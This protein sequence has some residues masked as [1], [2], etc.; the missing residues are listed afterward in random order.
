[1]DQ[2]A[3]YTATKLFLDA[4][5]LSADGI[6]LPKERF[7]EALSLLGTST[8]DVWLHYCCKTLQELSISD[9]SAAY[10]FADAVHNTRY[11]KGLEKGLLLWPHSFWDIEIEPFR[12]KYGQD[13]FRD[14]ID[15][16][17]PDTEV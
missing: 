17:Q 16:I 3:I 9:L 4:R 2:K 5:M 11:L 6:V 8:A 13:Y 10:D 1:M 14:F 7:I 15:Y 12:V